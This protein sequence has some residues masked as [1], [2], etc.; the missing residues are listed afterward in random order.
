M[1]VLLRE[2]AARIE[3][4]AFVIALIIL[5]LIGAPLHHWIM[6]SVLFLIVMAAE[7]LNT[8]IEVI[9]DRISPEHSD[10]ARDAKDLGSAG[11]FCSVLAAGLFLCAACL[12]AAGLISF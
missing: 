5:V 10:F 4:G 9:V 1:A 7:A 8:A 2:M 12:S 6:L 11:V 3:V